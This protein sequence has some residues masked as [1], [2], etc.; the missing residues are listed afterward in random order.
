M[1]AKKDHFVWGSFDDFSFPV[2]PDEVCVIQNKCVT[3]VIQ[4]RTA[5]IKVENGVV[6][7]G[8]SCLGII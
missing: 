3:D 6:A 1:E 7:A 8:K 2:T 5:T 4:G